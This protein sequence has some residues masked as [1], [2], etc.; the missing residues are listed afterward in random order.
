MNYAN[1]TLEQAKT[2]A[3]GLAHQATAAQ[4]EADRMRREGYSLLPALPGNKTRKLQVSVDALKGTSDYVFAIIENGYRSRAR[5]VQVTGPS[6][7]VVGNDAAYV[8]GIEEEEEVKDKRAAWV[9]TNSA[10]WVKW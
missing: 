8:C 10:L 5:D 9:E 2:D 3:M 7:F 1:E 4:S 6:R